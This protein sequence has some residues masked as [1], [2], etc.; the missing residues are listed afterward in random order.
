MLRHSNSSHIYH[1]P[2]TS[3]SQVTSGAFFSNYSGCML[4]MSAYFSAFQWC[5]MESKRGK[6]RRLELETQW[7]HVYRSS[8]VSIPGP[9]TVCY[10][11]QEALHDRHSCSEPH[12][13]SRM[14]T[15]TAKNQDSR[16]TLIWHNRANKLTKHY[17]DL[18][19]LFLIHVGCGYI[20]IHFCTFER[21]EKI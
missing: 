19:I 7:Q 6:W 3:L 9:S 4:I 14:Q 12:G 17:T 1:R 21:L 8:V 5:S 16:S 15:F 20:C 11:Q 2:W 13:H 18:N 10:I